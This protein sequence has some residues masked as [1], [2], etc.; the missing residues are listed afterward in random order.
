MRNLA[1]T[2]NYQTAKTTKTTVSLLY[3]N[4]KQPISNIIGIII[5]I[6]IIIMVKEIG[7]NHPSP[8]SLS[9]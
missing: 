6:M 1:A 3:T 8:S 5:I 4:V 7:N 9:G 2:Q